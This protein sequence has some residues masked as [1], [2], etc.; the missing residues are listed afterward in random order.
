M[1]KVNK[2]ILALDILRGISVAGMALV[3]HPGSWKAVYAP[4][5]HQLI[6]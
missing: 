6:Y 3:N 2:R 1:E 5:L 4:L